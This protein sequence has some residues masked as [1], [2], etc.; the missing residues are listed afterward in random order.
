[1][2]TKISAL[3]MKKAEFRLLRE[4]VTEAPWE[5]IF[6]ALGCINAG[7]FLSTIS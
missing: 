1:M 6:E 7:H 3:D 5:T 4:L 2:D